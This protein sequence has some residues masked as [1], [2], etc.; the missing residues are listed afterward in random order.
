MDYPVGRTRAGGVLRETAWI[1]AEPSGRQIDLTLGYETAL[2]SNA[3]GHAGWRI[4][5]EAWRSFEPRHRAGARPENSLYLA[6]SR[7]FIGC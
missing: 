3:A 2:P 4:R 7:G 5:L 1:G 6:V